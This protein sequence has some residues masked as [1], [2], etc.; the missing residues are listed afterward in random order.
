MDYELDREQKEIIKAAREF[1]KGEFSKLAEELDAQEKFSRELWKMAGELGFV[2]TWIPEEYEGPG[3]GFF[4]FALINE[5]FWA[6]DP[7]CG[8]QCTSTTFGAETVFLFGNEE[9]KKRWL[10]PLALGEAICGFGITEPGA[11]SDVTMVT[12]RAEKQGDEYVINGQKMFTTNGTIADFVFIFCQTDPENPNP[13]KRYSIICVETDRPGYEASKLTGKMGIR[14]ND[15][16]ELALK[17]LRVPKENLVGEEG[18]GFKQL[19]EFFNR[20]RLHVA[21]QGVGLARGAME[22]AVTHARTREQFGKPL[23]AFQAIKLKIAN[24]A[25][26]I[27]AARNLYYKAACQVDKGKVDHALISMAKWYGAR[28]A[29]EVVDEALQVHGGYGYLAEYDIS[30]LYRDAKIL[31]IYEGARE[32][33]LM[34]IADRFLGL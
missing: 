27:E 19:M 6:V 24:M 4:E 16:A 1:A 23:G 20:T 28:T 12:T 22:R 9:Q 8:Q 5:E 7:G 34:I 26:K 11:G 31:E 33:E 3:F 10:T 25:T 29:V 14:A 13:H 15:T 2:G 18:A 32:I 21:A 17:D 30:R